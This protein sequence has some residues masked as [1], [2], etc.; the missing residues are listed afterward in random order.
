VMNLD[1]AAGGRPRHS[2]LLAALA[3]APLELVELRVP[4]V[5]LLAELKVSE[6]LHIPF[7]LFKLSKI[8]GGGGEEVKGGI[9]E[10]TD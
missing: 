9:R 8:L 5:G 2:R 1:M 6:H 10:T 4:P 3:P 7:Y